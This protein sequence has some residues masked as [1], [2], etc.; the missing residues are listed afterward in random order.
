MH[1]MKIALPILRT[2]AKWEKY[3]RRPALMTERLLFAK[4]NQTLVIMTRVLQN[5]LVF[6]RKNIIG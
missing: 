4:K 3:K 2:S 5:L 1:K 6:N